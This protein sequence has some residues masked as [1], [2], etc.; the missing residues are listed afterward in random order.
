MEFLEIWSTVNMHALGTIV[1][2]VVCIDGLLMYGFITTERKFGL[3][4]R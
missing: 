2:Q 1:F 3:P 4:T